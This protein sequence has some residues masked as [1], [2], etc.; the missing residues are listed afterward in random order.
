MYG[1]KKTIKKSVYILYICSSIFIW[2]ISVKV[3]RKDNM[4]KNT[5]I[6][7]TVLHML[8]RM[9]SLRDNSDRLLVSPSMFVSPSS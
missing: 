4:I 2:F 7:Y 1:G 5:S 3:Q 9:D 8:N 6:W